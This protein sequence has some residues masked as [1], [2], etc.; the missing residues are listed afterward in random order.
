MGCGLQD[1]K[2]CW[3]HQRIIPRF[4]QKPVTCRC[5]RDPCPNKVSATDGSEMRGP[6]GWCQRG[7]GAQQSKCSSISPSFPPLCH[8][9]NYRLANSQ[10]PSHCDCIA[11][12][13]QEA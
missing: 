3:T 9:Q 6:H 4:H 8:V 1:Q 10:V 13:T 2:T 11:D 7:V 12:K 5:Y